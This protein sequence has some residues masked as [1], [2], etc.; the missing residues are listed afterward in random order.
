MPLPC[1]GVTHIVRH[2]HAS[3]CKVELTTDSI[4]VA[5]DGI[6]LDSAGTGDGHGLEGLRQR[7]QDNGADLTIEAPSSGS[8]T[9]LRVSARR[10]SSRMTHDVTE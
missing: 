10:L 7:C 3:H 1:E 4:E 2:A 8:G 5:D 6:G 9:V